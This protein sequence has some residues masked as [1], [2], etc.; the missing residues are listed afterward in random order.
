MP[1]STTI[2]QNRGVRTPA[3]PLVMFGC[4]MAPRPEGMRCF[5]SGRARRPRS[6]ALPGCRARDRLRR[7]NGPGRRASLSGLV[8]RVAPESP[9]S[10]PSGPGADGRRITAGPAQQ[11]HCLPSP[12]WGNA[13][14]ERPTLF[15]FTSV[16]ELFIA[17]SQKDLFGQPR[18]GRGSFSARPSSQLTSGGRRSAVIHRASRS[19]TG[20]GST[21]VAA[22]PC[23]AA[24]R[25]GAGAAADVNHPVGG[26]QLGGVGDGSRQ[27]APPGGHR[28]RGDDLPGPFREPHDDH[29]YG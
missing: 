24:C 23:R 26:C 8:I 25:G 21:P 18:S 27:R 9:G 11:H 7:C 1:V 19:M 16:E 3:P 28:Q 12:P 15:P 29:L 5:S 20:F 10:Q 17:L 6:L 14:P 22:A 4:S 2:T 13:Q